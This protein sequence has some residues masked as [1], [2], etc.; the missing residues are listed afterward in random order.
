MGFWRRRNRGKSEIDA[1]FSKM[2]AAAFPG[3]ESQIALETQAVVS[4]LDGRFS[5]EDARDIWIHAKGR[6]LLAVRSASTGDEALKTC[7]QSVMNRSH[8]LN[9][10]MAQKVSLYAFQRLV[11]QQ[12][13]SPVQ[14][15]TATWEGMTK[16]EAREIARI[17]M[18]RIARYQGR[19]MSKLQ[20]A[21]AFDPE[22]VIMAIAK[23]LLDGQKTVSLKKINTE[24]YE[25]EF[26]LNMAR[27]IVL[28]AEDGG[29][30]RS[31]Q[32]I[33][34]LAKRE[35][36]LTLQLV[37]NKESVEQY[38]DYD[39]S[40]WAAAQGLYVPFEIALRLGE[41]GILR[42]RPGPTSGRRNSMADIIGRMDAS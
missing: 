31:A 36:E 13:K 37:R 41:I 10:D 6:A 7:T 38:S 9:Q 1:I 12:N 14:G 23:E 33:D 29:S 16:E 35:L 30:S 3:G 28:V 8:A 24:G 32:E 40:E 39:V 15:M 26:A 27:R 21:Y 18:Y 5:E 19:T 42:N 22:F 17:T 11:D 20:E 25:L 34:R 4:L 2:A